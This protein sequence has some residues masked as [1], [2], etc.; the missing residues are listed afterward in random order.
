MKKYISIC[1]LM[2]NITFIYSQIPENDDNWQLEFEDEFTIPT[3]LDTYYSPR[4]YVNS[5]IH[6]DCA[7]S[8]TQELQCY[9][10]ANIEYQDGILKLVAKK[11]RIYERLNVFEPETAILSDGIQNKRWFDYTSGAIMTHSRESYGYFEIR[12]KIPK[13]KGF[14]PAFWL[15]HDP[16]CNKGREIDILELNGEASIT[17]NNYGATIHYSYISGTECKGGSSGMQIQNLPD[18]SLDYHT[19]SVEWTPSKVLFYLDNKLVRFL[20]HTY[21][22]SEGMHIIVNLAIDPWYSPNFSNFV[23]KSLDIDYIK[24]YKLKMDCGDP[25]TSSEGNNFNFSNF[26]Y[27]VKKSFSINNSTLIIGSKVTLR[28]TDFIEF[29]QNFNVPIGAEFNAI[30]VPCH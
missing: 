4:V 17:A 29:T 28:A 8:C 2:F 26:D 7:V 16:G 11:E 23:S 24:Y 10:K 6:G 12:C 3:L 18:L 5:L 27:K 25:I 22:P 21:V 1:L 9:Q 14:W 15:Y 19:Y 20:N 13:G 30:T